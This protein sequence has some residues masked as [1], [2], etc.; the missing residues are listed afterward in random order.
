M[1]RRLHLHSIEIID[2]ARAVLAEIA[3]T[4]VRSVCY[5]LFTRGLIADMGKNETGKVSRLLTRARESGVIPWHWIV[6]ETREIERAA[7]WSDGEVFIEQAVR[8]YRRDCWLD[9]PC[10]VEVISEKGTVRGVLAPVLDDFGVPFRVMHGFGS[11]TVLNDMACTINAA[12][13]PSILLYVGDYDPSGLYMSE[14]DLPERLMR[15]HADPEHYELRRVALTCEDAGR[16]PSF[17]ADAKR[18]D[19]RHEWFVRSYGAQC[20][21]LDAMNPN[22]L[23]E[24]VRHCIAACLDIDAWEHALMIQAAERESM[25]SFMGDWQRMLQGGR[26]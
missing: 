22:D 6:D 13:S 10:R 12:E 11:A 19:A 14:A 17:P 25:D 23:R 24:R 1:G 4:T 26:V 3:P 8:Q 9:Q 5:Q 16:L 15:Y 7:Q 2:T 18:G 21:E 20:W